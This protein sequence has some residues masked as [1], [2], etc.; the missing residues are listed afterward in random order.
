M[1]LSVPA[2][3]APSTGPA[4][5]G[6]AMAVGIDAF[7]EDFGDRTGTGYVLHAADVRFPLG[8]NVTALPFAEL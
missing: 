5:A 6:P 3:D 4:T 7:R 1:G 8:P 2:N